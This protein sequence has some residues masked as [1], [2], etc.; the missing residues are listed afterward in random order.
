M[1]FKIEDLGEDFR[2]VTVTVLDD[3]K[4]ALGVTVESNSYVAHLTRS[5]ALA[6]AGAMGA[7]ART[8]DRE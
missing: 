8:L 1:E 4:L 3:E 2:T 6:L 7:I 5:Q